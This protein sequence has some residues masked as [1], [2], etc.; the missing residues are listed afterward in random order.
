MAESSQRLAQQQAIAEMEMNAKLKI[1]DQQA[2]MQNQRLEIDNQYK[3]TMLGMQQEKMKQAAALQAQKISQASQR[4]E[5]IAGMDAD[6]KGGMEYK[7]AA[8]KWGTRIGWNPQQ[9]NPVIK[10]SAT[11]PEDVFHPANKETGEPPRYT[12]TKTGAIRFIPKP[13]ADP[14]VES[15][16]KILEGTISLLVKDREEAPRDKV[17]AKFDKRIEEKQAELRALLSPG[18]APIVRGE[19]IPKKNELK[20]GTVYRTKRGPAKWDGEQFIPE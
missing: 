4:Y 3:Q 19:D 16:R 17:K 7:D 15:Q 10:E 11:V 12:N 1:S 2:R 5:G 20:I 14:Y 6:I 13:D 8:L 9:M 18:S